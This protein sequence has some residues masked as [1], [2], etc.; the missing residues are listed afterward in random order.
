MLFQPEQ[1]SYSFVCGKMQ[2]CG[3]T[4]NGESATDVS[5]RERE[6]EIKQK[7]REE[8][9]RGEEEGIGGQKWEN[10]GIKKKNEEERKILEMGELEEK[11]IQ[12]SAEV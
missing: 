4:G 3:Q 12:R 7:L 10:K 6:R 5:E 8:T 1:G 11:G 2:R 9:E